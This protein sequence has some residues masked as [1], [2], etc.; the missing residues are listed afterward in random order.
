MKI[1]WVFPWVLPRDSRVKTS[2]F[3]KLHSRALDYS[4]LSTIPPTFFCFLFLSYI[5]LSIQKLNALFVGEH[6]KSP[7]LLR[8]HP[9]FFNCFP[10]G[11]L[12]TLLSTLYNNVLNVSVCGACPWNPI[13][14]FHIAHIPSF[15]TWTLVD[16]IPLPRYHPQIQYSKDKIGPL[17]F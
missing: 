10:L 11:C 4:F 1:H 3:G 16:T 2:L 12:P 8:P 13:L 7:L 5:R 9:P 6:I 17:N 15:L 14:G